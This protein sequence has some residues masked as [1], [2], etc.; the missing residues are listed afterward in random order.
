MQDIPDKGT[1][2]Q[3]VRRFLKA[4]LA[5]VIEDKSLR[6]RV[7]MIDPEGREEPGREAFECAYR[8]LADPPAVRLERP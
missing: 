1:L 4:D 5:A 6:F 3:A 7:L 8:D 2:L